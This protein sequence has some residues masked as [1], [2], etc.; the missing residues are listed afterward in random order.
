MAPPQGVEVD[1]LI[2][3]GSTGT[4]E[5]E[6]GGAPDTSTAPA[7]GSGGGGVA[8]AY[9]EG[10]DEAEVLRLRTERTQATLQKMKD[11]I[12]IRGIG[13]FVNET[14]G[15]AGDTTPGTPRKVWFIHPEGRFR[16]VWDMVQS[17]LLIYVAISVPL[18]L[19]FEIETAVSTADWYWELF[20][21][22]YFL[23]DVVLNF[24]TGIY[25]VDGALVHDRKRIRYSYLKGW[26]SIDCVSCFPAVYI[27][28]IVAAVDGS[29]GGGGGKIGNLKG[30]RILRLLRLAK[31]LRLGRLKRILCVLSWAGWGWGLWLPCVARAPGGGGNS[32]PVGGS[33][34]P[35]LTGTDACR[36]VIA[37]APRPQRPLR[38]GAAAYHQAGEADG[39]DLLRGLH[40]AHPGVP[41]VHG[42]GCQRHARARR[43]Q[44]LDAQRVVRRPLRPFWRPF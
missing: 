9:K 24:R 36:P 15:G 23:T 43:R 2:L 27:A 28:Q 18:R 29:G 5:V 7:A 25:D 4:F 19:G 30:I 35:V 20:V 3:P 13:C 21:D 11:R 6:A 22:A 1:A 32:G 26:F 37:A 44:H 8:G 39:H 12:E 10:V 31:M 42:G 41:V 17:V 33:A 16:K 34:Q 14:S 40:R 38:G